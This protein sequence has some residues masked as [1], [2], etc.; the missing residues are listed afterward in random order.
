MRYSLRTTDTSSLP[1]ILA[2]WG[3]ED[4]LSRC[5]KSSQSCILGWEPFR[6]FL[7]LSRPSAS[8]C[9][10]S[11]PLFTARLI[12]SRSL[13][14]LLRG[15]EWNVYPKDMTPRS[16]KPADLR[17]VGGR[18]KAARLAGG[19]TWKQMG[20]RLKLSA[21]SMKAKEASKRA[22][23]T[24]ELACWAKWGKCDVDWLVT[25]VGREPAQLS[26]VDHIKQ[27]GTEHLRRRPTRLERCM[28]C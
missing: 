16:M 26:M 12:L 3:G 24:G 28:A 15:I 4:P 23:S 20:Y 5:I 11:R 21:A 9:E 19:L 25:G 13:L 27:D 8:A 2:S 22:I 10:A 1:M 18:L 6:A 17:T 7:A 14:L